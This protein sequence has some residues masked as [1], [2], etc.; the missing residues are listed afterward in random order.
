V[1]HKVGPA[2]AAGN[3][4]VLKPAGYTP[5]IAELLVRLLL[6][7]GVPAAYLAL[8]QGSGRSVGQWL[9]EDPV[10]GFYAFTGS[11]EVGEHIHRTVGLPKCQ[12]EMGSLS[13]VIICDDADIDDC[14]GRCLD[15]AFRKAGQICTS[16]Q[17]LYVHRGVIDKVVDRLATLLANRRAGD[18]TDPNTF[19]GPLISLDNAQR[20]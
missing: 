7:A 16:I 10:P 19:I 6:D 3:G 17:R 20:V 5:T 1:L 11:T 12:L 18:T 15:A 14:I 8:L 4:V 9:L 2:L 13:S